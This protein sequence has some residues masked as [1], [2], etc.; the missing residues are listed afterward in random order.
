MY[1][2]IIHY[3]FTSGFKYKWLEKNIKS[4]VFFKR[5]KVAFFSNI[6]RGFLLNFFYLMFYLKIS[7]QS[8][9]WRQC[10]SR[11]CSLRS[12]CETK[13][14]IKPEANRSWDKRNVRWPCKGGIVLSASTKWLYIFSSGE[15]KTTSEGIV[16]SKGKVISL[17]FIC[18][19]N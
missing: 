15:T 4:I 1:K 19:F 2:L 13:T 14:F 3:V 5:I 10:Y 17:Y 16:Q 7:S 6:Q 11:Q 12:S 18:Y 8:D 9:L